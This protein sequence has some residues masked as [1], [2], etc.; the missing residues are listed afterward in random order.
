MPDGI[1][2]G[3]GAVAVRTVTAIW[4]LF[5]PVDRGDRG[6]GP[7]AR[8]SGPRRRGRGSR[9]AP[10]AGSAASPVDRRAARSLRC[11][12]RVRGRCARRRRSR[13]RAARD[14]GTHRMP[15][16]PVYVGSTSSASRSRVWCASWPSATW[17]LRWNVAQPRHAQSQACASLMVFRFYRVLTW[18]I[19]HWP[20]G[21]NASSS[22]HWQRRRRRRQLR[23]RDLQSRRKGIR[24]ST[25]D[26][27]AATPRAPLPHDRRRS[28]C[29]A[30]PDAASDSRYPEISL[31]PAL[32]CVLI[33][34]I[35]L[36][37]S[38]SISEAG[39]GIVSLPE[40][41]WGLL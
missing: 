20:V 23:D 13:A 25:C 28:G 37:S 12:R 32:I 3:R 8:G 27:P 11:G 30:A 6:S 24:T 7:P 35:H 5:A 9:P 38:W 15:A 39:K 16:G 14:R 29:A 34:T 10:A 36:L 19:E 33:F 1:Q 22:P 18:V 21:V 4:A 2:S 17:P 41:R 40:S 31:G 26:E